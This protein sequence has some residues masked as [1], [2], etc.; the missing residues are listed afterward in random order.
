MSVYAADA[1]EA[2]QSF[3][4]GYKF[5]P[6]FFK[7]NSVLINYWLLIKT[8]VYLRNRECVYACPSID[9]WLVSFLSCD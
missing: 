5:Q 3:D 9:I 6:K 7:I 1:E 8:N 4:T 2:M